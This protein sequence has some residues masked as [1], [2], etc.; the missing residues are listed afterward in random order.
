MKN[1]R[2][3]IIYCLIVSSRQRVNMYIEELIQIW[4]KL[5]FANLFSVNE[6]KQIPI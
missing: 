4:T 5:L 6:K 1:E 2:Q 3:K